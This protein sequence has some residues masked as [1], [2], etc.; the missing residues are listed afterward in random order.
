MCVLPPIIQFISIIADMEKYDRF[1]YTPLDG[2]IGLLILH[3]KYCMF[4]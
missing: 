4:S 2:G 3:M 1:Y